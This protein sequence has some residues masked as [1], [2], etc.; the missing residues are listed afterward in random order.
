MAGLAHQPPGDDYVW[1]IDPDVAGLNTMTMGMWAEVVN[2]W[3]GPGAV[4]QRHGHLAPGEQDDRRRRA[5][6][7]HGAGLHRHN[8]GAGVRRDGVVPLLDP[9]GIRP[10][11]GHRDIRHAQAQSTTRCSATWSGAQP[12]ATTS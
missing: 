9:R 2:R 12:P 10:A 4:D 6:S 11:P 7:G 8:G 1:Q 3:V 5:R